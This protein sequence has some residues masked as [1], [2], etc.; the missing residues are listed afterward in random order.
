MNIDISRKV[1]PHPL[2]NQ[3]M[4]VMWGLV[5]YSLFRYSPRPMRAW[6]RMLLRLFGAKLG[7]RVKV[8]G[9]AKIW[10]PWNLVM[11]DH[12]TIGPYVDCYCADTIRIGANSTVS[13]YSFLC[14]ATHDFTH[15]NMLLYT[16]PIVIGAAVWI[17]ADVYVGPGVTIRDGVVVGAR[18][19][20]F[21][22]LPPWTI[23][24]GSPAKP[25]GPRIVRQSGADNAQQSA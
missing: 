25:K 21:N 9:S 14:S 18:S 1:S 19:S 2:S 22:D 10:A 5:Y 16:R 12:S 11:D 4:R 24:V 20:V 17:C 6:R 23:C 7:K 13:Q 8:A 15:P 3:I